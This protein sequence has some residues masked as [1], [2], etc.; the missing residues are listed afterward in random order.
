[1]RKNVLV[2]GGSSSIGMACIKV[3]LSNNWVVHAHYN[4]N[5]KS[6]KKLKINNKNMLNLY[7]CDFAN[8]NQI[9]KFTNKIS[10]KK[11]CSIV[12]LIGYID[13]IKYKN[14][15]LKSLM[16]SLTINTIIPIMIEKKLL[17]YMIKIKFGRILNASSIGVK[18]GGG[19]YTYNY[20]FAKHALE[21]IPSYLRK[22]A[23]KNILTNVLR[24][25]FVKSKI[26]KKIKGKNIKKRISLIPMK[27]Q[28]VPSEI[29]NTI[30]NL[31]SDHNTY[32][33]NE[34]VTISGGE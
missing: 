3:F 14:S 16:K 26:H 33:S 15:S 5:N 27:R 8:Q 23:D 25:G 28:A 22:L 4:K 7:K 17:P 19:E 10:K 21:Y 13:N 12:N 24:I 32:I 20:S 29:A 9:N 18:Y 2:L 6:F 31:S 34:I 11:I 30:F 1:M